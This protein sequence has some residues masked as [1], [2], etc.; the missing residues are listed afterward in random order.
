MLFWQLR[1]A[2]RYWQRRH[3]GIPRRKSESI[4]ASECPSG[5]KCPSDSWEGR[6]TGRKHQ[7]WDSASSVG[8]SGKA[9]TGWS[10]GTDDNPSVTTLW[11]KTPLSQSSFQHIINT[12]I[13]KDLHGD[14]TSVLSLPI[15][16]QFESIPTHSCTH[17]DPPYHRTVL[18]PSPP[19]PEDRFGNIIN[20]LKC[21]VNWNFSFSCT[22]FVGYQELRLDKLR[23][24]RNSSR[25]T[26]S[27]CHVTVER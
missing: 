22:F 17:L 3:T 6:T 12:R 13:L 14:K 9:G 16:M 7:N 24:C 2:R 21:H 23:S 25:S 11:H 27:G 5:G 15:P 26:A 1:R 4:H 19:I 10:V 20:W 18:F 8:R